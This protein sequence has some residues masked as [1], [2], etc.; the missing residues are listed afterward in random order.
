MSMML[1]VLGYDVDC[2]RNGREAV[3]AFERRDY[4]AVLM[5]CQMPEVDGYGATRLI[6]RREAAGRRVPI[7]AVTGLVIE[8]ERDRCLAAGMD[9]FL[10]KPV[11]MGIL[12]AVLD[13][14]LSR[15]GR[16]GSPR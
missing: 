7:L 11:P 13:G 9:E 5:D 10:S 6:R 15:N 2:V 14:L 16:G 4:D 12:E 8:G 1:R 3:D